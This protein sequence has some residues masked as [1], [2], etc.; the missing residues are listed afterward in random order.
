MYSILHETDDATAVNLSAYG[1][2]LPCFGRQLVTAGAKSLKFYRANPFAQIE[3]DQNWIETT[4]LEC[5][6]TFNLMAPIRAMNI[7]RIPCKYKLFDI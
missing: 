1:K 6:M 2:F 3:T 4:R 7:A 5:L